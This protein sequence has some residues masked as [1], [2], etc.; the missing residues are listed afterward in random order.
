MLP[1]KLRKHQFYLSL[2]IFH[3]YKFQLVSCNLS[4]AMIWQMTYTHKLP[5]LC[6]AT[7]KESTLISVNVQ[8]IFAL[9][10]IAF[11]PSRNHTGQQSATQPFLVSS[12]NRGTLRD[13]TKTAVQQ[14]NWI[15]FLFTHNKNFGGAFFVTVHRWA[16]P[17]SKVKRRHIGQILCRTL[18]Q[19]FRFFVRCLVQLF[20][21]F[22]FHS[23][24]C[25]P[26]CP[27][28]CP[29]SFVQRM[30]LAFESLSRY[31]NQIRMLFKFCTFVIFSGSKHLRS[32]SDMFT[33][34]GKKHQDLEDL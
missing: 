19:C 29:I 30:S 18:V 3:Q 14:T 16:V 1:W 22:S 11:A 21:Q 6:S 32:A 9:Y 26:F 8:A 7:L 31:N 20:V 5:K 4:L 25:P 10:R 12:R 27:L 28:F 33:S 34:P 17:N 2:K 24:F 13:D 23:T 15:G